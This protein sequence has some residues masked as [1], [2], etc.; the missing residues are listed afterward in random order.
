[1]GP[2]A[3]LDAYFEDKNILSLMGI[4]SLFLSCPAC[5]LI[6]SPDL[7]RII[8][9]I[10]TIKEKGNVVLVRT[11]KTCWGIKILAPFFFLIRSLV[12]ASG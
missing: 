11:M 10:V 7:L 9:C 5:S 4:E 8:Q 3:G 6:T 1:M 2:T 12:E